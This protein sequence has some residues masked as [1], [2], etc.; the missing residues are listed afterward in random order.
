[1]AL[2]RT[3]QQTIEDKRR[4]LK[5]ISEKY[6]WLKGLL[7]RNLG[8]EPKPSNE[9]LLPFPYILVA[10]QDDPTN[11]VSIRLNTTNTKVWSSFSKPIKIVGDSDSIVHFRLKRDYTVL[12]Q[13]VRDVLNKS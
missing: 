12:P 3:K 13:E 5:E 10:T 7:E 6:V 8:Q 1:M 9:E 4:D 11:S 2:I